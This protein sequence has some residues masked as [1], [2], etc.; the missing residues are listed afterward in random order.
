MYVMYV[1]VVNG[2]L[3]RITHWRTVTTTMPWFQIKPNASCW[4]VPGTIQQ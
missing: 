2:N 3:G 4:L 1:P